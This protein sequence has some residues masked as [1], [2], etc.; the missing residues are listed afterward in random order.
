MLSLLKK[1]PIIFICLGIAVVLLPNLHIMDVTIMEARNFIT[2]REMLTDNNWLLTTMNGEAR[3]E[4]PPL[5]TWLTAVSTAIFGVKSVF[6]MRLP[7]VIFI[8]IVAAFVFKLSKKISDSQSFGVLSAIIVT[9]SFYVV[10]IMIEAPWDIFAHG[11]MCVAIYYL[12]AFFEAKNT[13]WNSAILASIFIGFSILSKGPV[14][15][16]ALLLP[17]LLAYGFTYKYKQFNKKFLPSIFILILAI[18]VGGWWYLYVRL[19]DPTTFLAITEKETGNWSNYNVRPFYYYWSFF[20]QSGLWTI[21]AFVSLLYPYLKTR[22][23][24]LKG[25]Q[26]SL[27]WTLLAVVLLSIIP[28]KK[29][30]YLM[31]VLIP[32]AINCSFYIDYL[33]REF[34]NLSDKRET[35]PVYFNFGLIG[36]IGIAFPITTFIFLKDNL[37]GYWFNY[38]LASVLVFNIGVLIFINLRRKNIK[39]VVTFAAGL[40]AALLLTALPLKE[41]LNSDSFHPISS[42][43]TGDLKLYQLSYIA[44]EMI[45]EYGQKIPQIKKDDGSISF[46]KDFSFALLAMNLNAKD[47]EAIQQYYTIEK[48]TTFDLNTVSKESRQYKDRLVATYYKIIKK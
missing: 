22:V 13:Q 16:Y 39:L 20:T 15:F 43:F 18:A 23:K 17:F 48:I 21:P 38:I 5:P 41:A 30:R 45:W 3:Y 28:E 8:M 40:Y 27:L 9:T 2:A 25:Y 34:K 7:A 12:F 47:S 14:S 42:S 35:L 44:P 24:N 31:P 10:G 6:A 36:L 37:Q 32:L 11:F 1:H 29:S 26:F 4:K 46:P 33:I 19:E